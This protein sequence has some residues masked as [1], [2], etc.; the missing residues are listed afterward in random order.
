MFEFKGTY[1]DKTLKYMNIKFIKGLVFV[2]AFTTIFLIP[3]V[4]PL[5]DLFGSKWAPWSFVLVFPCEAL[6]IGIIM[7]VD[8]KRLA[9][10]F[11]K[12]I[13]TEDE[14]ITFISEK[15][16]IYITTDNIKTV[17]DFG[18]FYHIKPKR[19]KGPLNLICQK[20]MLTGGTIE[21]FEAIFEGKI[22]RKYEEES[23]NG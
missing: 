4:Y 13:Y 22:V 14:Y 21:E 5:G 2:V 18:D 12:K 10:G 7:S 9:V 20:D 15:Y 8:K 17:L 11:P 3:I 6:V 19:G 23:E 16:D 1:S